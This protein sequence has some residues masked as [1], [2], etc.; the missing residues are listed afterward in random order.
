MPP[1]PLLVSPEEEER[2]EG[3]LTRDEEGEWFLRF[4]CGLTKYAAQAAQ[5]QRGS[6][7]IL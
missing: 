6:L 2:E 5:A 3:G 4:H 7:Y 1:P